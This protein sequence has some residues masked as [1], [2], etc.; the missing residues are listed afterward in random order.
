MT[1]ATPPRPFL[2]VFDTC[3]HPRYYGDVH[4]VLSLPAGAM[5][6]YEYK[7]SLFKH[8]AAE[9]F[10]RLL[11]QPEALPVDVLLM[12]G[13]MKGYRQGDPDPDRMLRWADGVFV[14]TRSAK[15]V[16]IAR[17]QGADAQSDVLYLHLQMRGFV[18]PA[19]APIEAMIRALEA[20]DALPFGDRGSQHAWISLLPQA[21]EAQRSQLTSDNQNLWSRIVD[22]LIVTPTQFRS[23]IFWR[24][25]RVAKANRSD[26]AALELSDRRYNTPAHTD[27]SHRDYVLVEGSRYEL[28]VQTHSPDAHGHQIPGNATIVMTT[29][30][31]DEGLV[32]LSARPLDIVP[33]ETSSQRFSIDTNNTI[34]TR[35]VEIHLETQTPDHASVYPPGSLCTLT[36]AIRKQH[37]RLALGAVLVLASTALGGYAAAVPISPA[38]KAGL[39][40][41][42]AVLLAAGGWILTR[43]FKILK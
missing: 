36:F 24:V 13:E 34:D 9:S 31:D 25:S 23:D 26:E 16:G 7:R 40:V 28:F 39:A 35:Y 3:T 4:Q 2:V 29:N 1:N 19:T 33:N 20:A 11:A 6:R 42:V 12:Y 5:V 14:P 21:L 30:Q 38:A 27:R 22:A 18:D 37:W 15:L 43:Q 41:V 10:D 8:N 17:T 32:R